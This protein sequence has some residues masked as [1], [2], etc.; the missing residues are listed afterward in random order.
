MFLLS[1]SIFILMSLLI[2]VQFII[3][4]KDKNRIK[5][6]KLYAKIFE[7]THECVLIT[8]A[9]KKIIEV[10]NALLKTTGY[11]KEELT[12]QMPN[13]FNSG[14][15]DSE[16]YQQMWESIT[17]NNS[18]E[19]EI[20]NRKKGGTL[21]GQWLRI[22][23]FKD[24][25]DNIINYIGISSALAEKQI[26]QNHI[27]K[28]L[29]YDILTG[30]P[31]ENL[32]LDRLKQAISNAKRK[33]ANI[34]LLH[35]NIDNFNLI[36]ESFNY[37][38]GDKFLQLAS[39]IFMQNLRETDTIA[40]LER[41]DFVVIL[42]GITNAI[43]PGF[44]AKRL[45]DAFSESFVVD[46]QHISST[47]SIGISLFPYDTREMSELIQFANTAMFKAKKRG[48]NNFQ[49]FQANSKQCILEKSTIENKL[50]KAISKNEL[51]IYYLPLLNIYENSVIGLEALIRWK[52]S[53]L[54]FVSPDKFISI[55]EETNLIIDLTDWV[56]SNSCKQLL[57]FHALGYEDLRLSINISSNYLKQEN[58][59]KHV[60]KILNQI[61]IDPHYLE[62]EITE[63][64]FIDSIDDTINKLNTFKNKGIE[65]SVDDFG[66]G[67]ASFNYLKRFPI[68]KLKIDKS[69]ILKIPDD[70]NN[71]EIVTAI[72]S[73]A[74]ALELQI[75]AEGVET[76]AQLNFLKEK[77][78]PFVQGFFFSKP[79]KPEDVIDFL[80]N[81]A[82]DELGLKVYKLE[83]VVK[84]YAIV[85]N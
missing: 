67:Q 58:I 28:I 68:D 69:L 38:I 65:I 70:K 14:W 37:K 83:K 53:D 62:F 56:I 47:I 55:A 8:D 21:F 33:N 6:L 24:N 49:L 41:D 66:T 11:S 40:R 52:N 25:N 57:Q 15:N 5:Y 16:F 10:N 36:N 27:H 43:K 20:W 75:V 32:F 72:I 19:G 74:N 85:E 26:S 2:W 50:R 1:V 30:L 12:N 46:E 77:S 80:E 48:K 73:L 63:K 31:N 76:E 82:K 71:I 79:L 61:K 3:I 22:I 34:A 51:F 23:P 64:A 60:F 78:C 59:C 17:N 84:E 18:W 9:D 45:I 13:I 42:Q 4:H 39:N 81:I 35:I 7:K 29:Y 44:I 54:G